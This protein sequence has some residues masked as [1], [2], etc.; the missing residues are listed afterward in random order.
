MWPVDLQVRKN[1]IKIKMSLIPS[2]SESCLVLSW[3]PGEGYWGGMVFSDTSLFSQDPVWLAGSSA[4]SPPPGTG[5]I[6]NHHMPLRAEDT[7]TDHWMRMKICPLCLRWLLPSLF[8]SH[9]IGLWKRPGSL[10][11]TD[12]K[13]GTSRFSKDTRVHGFPQKFFKVWL[14][15]EMSSVSPHSSDIVKCSGK[16]R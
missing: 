12:A 1:K 14:N 13:R 11:S 2:V 16:P 8:F 15:Y 7:A 5:C 4:S 6:N 3:S 10:Y 9:F